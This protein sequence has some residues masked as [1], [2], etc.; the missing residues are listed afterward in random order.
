MSVHCPQSQAAAP[1]RAC[2]LLKVCPGP[3]LQWLPLSVPSGT[4]ALVAQTLLTILPGLRHPGSTSLH[5]TYNTSSRL[6]SPL[7]TDDG[8]ATPSP[9]G[10][11]LAFTSTELTEAP[12][13]HR[14]GGQGAPWVH[15]PPPRTPIPGPHSAGHLGPQT[16]SLMSAL[17]LST[18]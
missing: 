12:E 16:S 7:L 10:T 15:R 1:A 13:A 8:W 17:G 18:R 2:S 3:S 9:R 4:P 6:P 14:W 5:K 11:S